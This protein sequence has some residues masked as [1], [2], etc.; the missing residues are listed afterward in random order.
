MKDELNVKKDAERIPEKADIPQDK[1]ES[2]KNPA[3]ASQYKFLAK[4][5]QVRVWVEREKY[6]KFKEAVKKNGTS[7]YKLIN[8]FVDWYLSQ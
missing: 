8:D 5:S 1:T 4:R 2:G 6:L 3:Y 7:I